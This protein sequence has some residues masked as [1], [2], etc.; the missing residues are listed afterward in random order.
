LFVDGRANSNQ[1]YS[2]YRNEYR[3][4]KSKKIAHLQRSTL[5]GSTEPEKWHYDSRFTA[6]LRPKGMVT[7]G[8][9]KRSYT[10]ESTL[11]ILAW[12]IH[13]GGQLSYGSIFASGGDQTMWHSRLMQLVLSGFAAQFP[14]P[15]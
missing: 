7:K 1:D 6:R 12:V 8:G 4:Y 11:T 13:E 10:F 5:P 2:E 9:R 15:S 3:Q 14:D